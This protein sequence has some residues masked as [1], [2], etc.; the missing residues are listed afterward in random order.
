VSAGMQ[1][2]PPSAMKDH[3]F[4]QF[5]SFIHEVVGIQLPRTKKTML[6]ARLQKRLKILGIGTFEAYREYVFSPE[7]QAAELIHLIDVV[8]TNKTDF[9]REPG[10]F[11]FLTRNALPKIVKHWGTVF[12]E[13]LRVWC[14]GCAPETTDTCCCSGKEDSDFPMTAYRLGI[15]PAFAGY[16]AASRVLPADRYPRT[17]G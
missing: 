5:S 4:Q 13:P 15:T 12:S 9:F 8:T 2:R 7:G 10:H 6:E 3:D 1:F 17:G 16:G 14:C 11:D